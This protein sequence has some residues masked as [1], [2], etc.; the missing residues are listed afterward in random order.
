[1][2]L[3]VDLFAQLPN[4]YVLYIVYGCNKFLLLDYNSDLRVKF[5]RSLDRAYVHE[6]GFLVLVFSTY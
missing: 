3:G 1:M 6:I 2:T 5:I 4:C